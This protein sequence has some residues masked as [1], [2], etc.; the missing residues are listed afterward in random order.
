MHSLVAGYP[1][2]LLSTICARV[3]WAGFPPLISSLDP[4]LG[5]G[6]DAPTH[7]PS[8]FPQAAWSESIS[9][10]TLAFLCSVSRAWYAAAKP[11][12]WHRVEVRLP[13]TWLALLD[14][15]ATEDWEDLTAEGAA[16]VV[17]PFIR[18]ITH[19]ALAAK[20]TASSSK[21]EAEML[22]RRIFASLSLPDISIPPELL[23][24]PASRDPSPRRL[25]RQSKSPTRWRFMRS[26]SDA[27]MTVIQR[28]QPEVY[29]PSFQDVHPGRHVFHLNFNHF[30]TVGMRRSV[31]EGIHRRFVTDVRLE[32]VLKAS[33]EMPNLRVFGA[34][35]Y[36]DGAL[37]FPVLEE[38]FMRGPTESDASARGRSRI[39]VPHTTPEDEDRDRWAQCSALE[40]VDLTGCVSSVFVAA[41]T[42]FVNLHLRNTEQRRLSNSP[43]TAGGAE[44]ASPGRENRPLVTLRG[45]K[46]LGMRGTKSIPAD[47]F[48]TFVLSMPHLTHLDLSCTRITPDLLSLLA[49][50]STVHLHTLSL[51]RCTRL[52]GESIRSFLVSAPAARH[53][54]E[55]NLYGDGT[56]PSP[57]SA[58][59]VREIFE[60]APCF[61]SRSLVYLDVSSAPL[62][63]E[64]L[65]KVL[66][67]QPF[68]RSLG[69]A[70]I[71]NLELVHIRKFLEEKAADTE[72]LTLVG[73]SPELGY[74][75]ERVSVR[76]ASLSLHTGLITPLCRPPFSLSANLPQP[77]TRLRV[78]ELSIPLLSGLG[79]GAGS[80]RVIRSKGGRGWY[81]DTGSGWIGAASGEDGQG[82]GDKPMLARDL[83]VGHPW[84]VELENLANANGNVSSGVGWHARKMEV[85]HGHGML[86]REDGLYGAV[87]FAYQG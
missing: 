65:T 40:A 70:H 53:I 36:M 4:L 63:A 81:V 44:R 7:L 1:Q 84:R 13:Y 56:F 60:T 51:E 45:I 47:V 26:L 32:A 19:A 64:L 31:D 57:L 62:D 28:E 11:W 21:E 12:L 33:R 85:L 23:S 14:V 41:L 54:R 30:R 55:L 16:L 37:T 43:F 77:P 46:R 29:V 83:P 69:L 35:E 52:T 22:E 73:T 59:D 74:G 17:G 61:T 67:P 34:T 2:E 48:S 80:W 66:P 78:V 72:V 42:E 39:A 24:P 10:K 86:G 5:D 27:V 49:K 87:A 76:Q 71:P 15:I 6:H 79:G 75:R 58:E 50:S 20:P 8:S 25:R 38:L 18:E 68:L 3:Y 82:S 9:R